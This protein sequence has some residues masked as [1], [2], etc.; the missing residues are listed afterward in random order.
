MLPYMSLDQLNARGDWFKQRGPMQ[1]YWRYGRFHMGVYKRPEADRTI[2]LIFRAVPTAFSTN[3][4]DQSPELADVWHPLIGDVGAALLLLKEGNIQIE[5]ARGMLTKAF[6]KEL[7]G[8]I[9]QAVGRQQ[10]TSPVHVRTREE[11]EVAS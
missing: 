1:G 3:T 8:P 11:A 4:M 10:R 7:F 9:K 2:T 6:G 5:K